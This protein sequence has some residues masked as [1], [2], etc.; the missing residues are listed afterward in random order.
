MEEAIS[1]WLV[2]EAVGLAAFPIAFVFLRGL[3]DRGYS[4]AKVLGLLLLAYSLWI[5]ATI[6]VFP[7]S[8]GAVIGLL[9]ALALVGFAMAY[10]HRG[11]MLRFLSRNA[12]YVFTVEALFAGAFFLSLW[13]R[14][15]VAGIYNIEKPMD[16]AMLNAVFR[17][18]SFPPSDPWLAGSS[19]N[20]YYFG[21]V[22]HAA[23]V[24]LLGIASSIG[25]NLALAGT[26]ALGAI[27]AF[28][29]LYN[30]VAHNGKGAEKGWFLTLQALGFGALAVVFLFI[31]SNLVG[32]FEM[33]TVHGI[34]EPSDYGWLHIKGL[35]EP[36]HTNTWYPI[37]HWWWP[38]AITF[39]TWSEFPFFSFVLGDLHPH[40]LAI[41]F[42]LLAIGVALSFLL[43]DSDDLW[44][45]W[46]RPARLVLTGLVFGALGF[47]HS[48][49]MPVG[50][51]FL[52][53]VVF[54]K[55]YQLAGGLT[56]PMLLRVGGYLASVI[57]IALAAYSPF[58]LGFDNP[59][60]LAFTTGPTVRPV[61]L[62]V[63]WGTLLVLAF[64]F[65]LFAI[66]RHPLGWR[67]TRGQLGIA[68]ALGALPVLVWTVG[69]LVKSANTGDLPHFTWGW[70]TV[71][72][73][74]SLFFLLAL[75]V[76][77]HLPVARDSEDGLPLLFALAAAGVGTLLILGPE[78]FVILDP[79]RLRVNTV[80][81][82]WYQAWFYLGLSG[83]F[84][85]YWITRSWRPQRM[86]S[87]LGLHSW[88]IVVVL[89]VLAGLVYPV[90]ATYSRTSN[91][92]A[93]RTVDGLAFVRRGDPNEYAAIQWL[94]RNA[95]SSTVILEAWGG[96]YTDFG[97]VSG[98]TGLPTVLGWYAHERQWRGIQPE[99]LDIRR[100]DVERAYCTTDPLVA[101]AILEKYNV[102]YVYAGRLEQLRYVDQDIS[103]GERKT[104]VEECQ[105]DP[106]VRQQ[107]L[108]KFGQFMDVAYRNDE[109]TIYRVREET[110]AA[111]DR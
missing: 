56:R 49:N 53:V 28:G 59:T 92:S 67:F 61:H 93:E 83:A 31:L 12:A 79:M 1:W 57:V 43:S 32:V 9:V 102:E 44:E 30:L 80:L 50:L 100:A 90:I 14:S 26:L 101:R 62:F 33:L 77:R 96:D 68:L 74:S 47:I 20:Y 94:S 17:A 65:A 64:S 81:K 25:Y 60:E 6:G 54:F 16:F 40:V 51:F 95:D 97:R 89:F 86:L 52:A 66:F 34:G 99:L 58:F 39:F 15:H 42:T 7:N 23:P 108:A 21:Y 2:I 4:L 88:L 110:S 82:S 3:R 70:G 29:I 107:F 75:A 41:P 37:E 19:V 103:E 105:R 8:R 73:L 22:I 55:G 18:D 72:I 27:A 106:Q 35:D 78:F 10:R 63:F 46:R 36:R 98:R 109:V 76:V 87:W 85:I 48:W 5:G 38:R 13:L 84:A 11:E 91:F 24:M 71:A 45:F 104:L 111:V 69:H